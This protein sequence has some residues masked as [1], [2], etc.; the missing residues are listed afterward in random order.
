MSVAKADFR[1]QKGG[2]CSSSQVGGAGGSGGGGG[3]GG[4][5]GGNGGEG[6]A[7]ASGGA[8]QMYGSDCLQGARSQPY[9][10]SVLPAAVRYC[11]CDSCEDL[12]SVPR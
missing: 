1:Y 8:S 3:L 6:Q 7:N 4:L 10:R 11:C 5:G 9:L 2:H 12:S